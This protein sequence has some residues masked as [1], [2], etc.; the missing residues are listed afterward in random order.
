MPFFYSKG[1]HPIDT[2]EKALL[3]DYYANTLNPI[4]NKRNFDEIDRQIDNLGR[5]SKKNFDEID[6]SV[7][8][9]FLKRFFLERPRSQ[10]Q[11]PSEQRFH[12]VDHNDYQDYLKH[13]VNDDRVVK[14]NFDEIDRF[15]SSLVSKGND[16]Y[17][18]KKTYPQE[19][20]MN[21]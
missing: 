1:H 8:D 11:V 18:S 15:V 9:P 13:V 10:P 19:M 5:M 3:Y 12:E 7:I 16:R 4:L 20:K 14:R 21:E 2:D 17:K 6:R